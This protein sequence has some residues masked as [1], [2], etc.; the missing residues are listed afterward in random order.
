M[1]KFILLIAFAAIANT[2]FA[3]FGV[4]GGLNYSGV[5][6]DQDYEDLKG[7]ANFLV[8]ALYQIN[9]TDNFGIRPEAI[10]IR[11]GATYDVLGLDADFKSDYFEIPVMAVIGLGSLPINI[12]LGPQFSYLLSSQYSLGGTEIEFGDD[13]LENVDYG[14]ALGIGAKINNFLID[15]RYTRGLK[16]YDKDSSDGGVTIEASSKHFG[17][18]AAVGL[19]F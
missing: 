19:T 16:N 14:A 8:G 4:K 11:K 5:T 1:K 9:I 10:Y 15:L 18:Q 7:Q 6:T 13:E 17:L 12:Q 2:T 3:Q